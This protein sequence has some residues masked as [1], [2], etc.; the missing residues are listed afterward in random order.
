M[1]SSNACRFF[2]WDPFARTPRERATVKALRANADDV[3][4]SIR[5]RA[6]WARLYRERQAAVAGR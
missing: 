5:S 6:E 2:S 3:D 1:W 4:V